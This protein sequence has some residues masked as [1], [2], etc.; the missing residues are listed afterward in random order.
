LAQSPDEVEIPMLQSLPQTALKR[1]VA[2]SGAA[3]GTGVPASADARAATDAAGRPLGRGGSAGSLLPA[4][5]LATAPQP[6]GR[7][8]LASALPRGVFIAP[9]G[10]LSTPLPLPGARLPPGAVPGQVPPAPGA[11]LPWAAVS[12]S[13][14]APAAIAAALP[15]APPPTIP[16]VFQT[17][18]ELPGALRGAIEGVRIQLYLYA[19]AAR[20]RWLMVGGKRLREGE[21]LVDGVRLEEITPQGLVLSQGAQRF[22]VKTASLRGS[23]V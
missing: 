8:P 19:P 9:P 23:A 1:A 15:V 2:A 16:V 10:S 7:L 12:T 22:Q 4:A 14:M 18:D 13:G 21:D 3:S 5:W 6:T 11:A 20:Q 17:L